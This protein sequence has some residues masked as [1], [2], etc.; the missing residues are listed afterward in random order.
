[1]NH[2]AVELH[3][4]VM[5]DTGFQHRRRTPRWQSGR[6]TRNSLGRFMRPKPAARKP[7]CASTPT[8]Q[9]ITRMGHW[10]REFP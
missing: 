1:M 8:I 5:A 4:F 3:L 2:K 9:I 10:S 6:S 7:S